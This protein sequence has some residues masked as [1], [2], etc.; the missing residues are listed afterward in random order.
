MTHVPLAPRSQPLG[1]VTV[2]PHTAFRGVFLKERPNPVTALLHLFQWLHCLLRTKCKCLSIVHRALGPSGL[3]FLPTSSHVPLLVA[4]EHQTTFIPFPIPHW[5]LSPSCSFSSLSQCLCLWSIP[6]L[7]RLSSQ[8]FLGGLF[9]EMQLK[10]H[11]F[12]EASPT[13]PLH[14]HDRVGQGCFCS[15]PGASGISPH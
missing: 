6:R 10:C 13:T 2:T 1:M 15:Y 14:T 9:S 8:P 7:E 5:T 4:H 11:L 12:Q 3:T